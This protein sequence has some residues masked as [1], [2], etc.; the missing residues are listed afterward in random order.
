MLLKHQKQPEHVFVD[1]L[2]RAPNNTVAAL[3]KLREE[4]LEKMKTDVDTCTQGQSRAE[5]VRGLSMAFLHTSAEFLTKACEKGMRQGTWPLKAWCRVHKKLCPTKPVLGD[6]SLW[7]EVAGNTCTPFSAS[8][9]SLGF[10]DKNSMASLVW[11]AWLGV[12]QPDAIINECTERW[13]AQE[14]FQTWLQQS[15]SMGSIKVGPDDFGLPI[16]RRRLY[17]CL[18]REASTSAGQPWPQSLSTLFR[19]V[20]TD[21]GI[22]FC[23]AGSAKRSQVTAVCQQSRYPR[24]RQLR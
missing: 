12:V 14:F 24:Q 21:A 15:Y 5:A 13:P 17:T 20:D 16:R 7:L 6:K 1:L 18:S 10:L 23:A 11:G 4:A 3:D 2:H 8:G 9:L 19:D 22:F